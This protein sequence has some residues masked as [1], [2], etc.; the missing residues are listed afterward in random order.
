M[1][2]T[3]PSGSLGCVFYPDTAEFYHG[4][5][6]QPASEGTL[7]LRA[8][9]PIFEGHPEPLSFRLQ[10]KLFASVHLKT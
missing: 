8:L 10:W 5:S 6:G 4:L 1:V 3:R 7:D 9:G 2:P